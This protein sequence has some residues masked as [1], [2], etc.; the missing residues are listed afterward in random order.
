MRD[1]RHHQRQG[2]QARPRRQ[3][4]PR[5]GRNHAD[6]VLHQDRG[7]RK[8]LKTYSNGVGRTYSNGVGSV[9]TVHADFFDFSP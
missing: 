7:V 1:E 4:F 5:R 8:Q 2:R 3:R 6:A 9:Q